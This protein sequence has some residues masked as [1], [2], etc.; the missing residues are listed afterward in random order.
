MILLSK[1]LGLTLVPM[2]L[3]PVDRA[4]LRI[5]SLSILILGL[6][7]LTF[8][9]VILGLLPRDKA[10][11]LSEERRVYSSDMWDEN[12][13]MVKLRDATVL[14]I[15]VPMHEDHHFRTLSCHCESYFPNMIVLHHIYLHLNSVNL[16]F[17]QTFR[18]FLLV[19]PICHL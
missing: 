16:W 6:F 8:D 12:I 18:I 2:V 13:C 19:S 9:G 14:I 15:E 17:R 10:T 7:S 4:V 5:F 11:P 3:V 1:W